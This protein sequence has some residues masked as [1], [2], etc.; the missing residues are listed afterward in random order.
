MVSEPSCRHCH[1]AYPR[2]RQSVGTDGQSHLA[3]G[4]HTLPIS[5]IVVPLA[6]H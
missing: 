4:V 5:K 2:R 1:G 3:D 6:C